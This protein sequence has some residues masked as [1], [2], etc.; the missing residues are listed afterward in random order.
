MRIQGFDEKT[1]GAYIYEWA[2][3]GRDIHQPLQYSEDAS[4]FQVGRVGG[5]KNG[6]VI[7][8]STLMGF[9]SIR[10]TRMCTFQGLGIQLGFFLVL[11]LEFLWFTL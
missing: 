9:F 8:M 4:T 11:Q 1:I 3:T 2:Y 5:Q 7:Y 10:M 6:Y